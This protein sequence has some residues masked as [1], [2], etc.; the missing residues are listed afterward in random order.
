MLPGYC[1]IFDLCPVRGLSQFRAFHF[2]LR[3]LPQIPPQYLPYGIL[4][5]FIDERNASS[6]LFVRRHLCSHVPLHLVR[7]DLAPCFANHIRPG[8]IPRSRIRQANDSCLFDLWMTAEKAF[9]LRWCNLKAFV[10][11]EFLQ[12]PSADVHAVQLKQ[13]S[14]ER[15]T[16]LRSTT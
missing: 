12:L 8:Q 14:T 2:L 3:P 9:E 4:G 11:E 5:Y 16:F 7:R 10:L 15:Q 1:L 13:T 6:Q